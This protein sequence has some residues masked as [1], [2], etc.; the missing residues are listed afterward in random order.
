[1]R[2]L[3]SLLSTPGNRP[4][5]LEK[6][7][8]SEAD[9]L[10]VDLEDSVPAAER[11][12]ARVLVRE[13]IDAHGG[14]A[15]LYV[16]VN[17]AGSPFVADDVE[18]IV[19]PGLVGVQLPKADGPE[20]VLALAELLDRA[21]RTA[22]V[23]PGSVEILVSLESA[24]AVV[25]AYEI[26]T[27]SPR[28]GSAMPGVAENGDLQ[29]D[30]G[31]LYTPDEEALQHTRAHVLLAARAAGLENP[32][33]GVYGRVDDDAAFEASAMIARR[34]G[35]RGKKLIHPR[36]IAIANRVFMPSEQELEFHRRVLEALDDAEARGT[37][38]TVVDG[39]MVD[40][41][42]AVTARRMLAWAAET[43]AR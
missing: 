37:A 26:L 30:L 12:Q 25:R 14:D 19:A 10:V 21:E 22:G 41:A 8:A 2:S 38:A 36:H 43:G 13:L 29:R 4:A 39:Q 20:D 15:V 33:D 35:Y 42:M 16:R 40:A 5:M 31:F 27:A 24:V 32:I 23:E 17:P 3:R 9:A 1:M 18:A 11:P 34:L 28:V 7:L 6:A